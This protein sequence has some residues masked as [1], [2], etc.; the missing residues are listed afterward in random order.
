MNVKTDSWL[1]KTLNNANMANKQKRR[2]NSAVPH[3]SESSNSSVTENEQTIPVVSLVTNSTVTTVATTVKNL[4]QTI[5][6]RKS[7]ISLNND[8]TTSEETKRVIG[9]ATYSETVRRYTSLNTSLSE[10][11]EFCKK[12]K[13]NIANVSTICSTVIPIPGRKCQRKDFEKSYYLLHNRSCKCSR[14]RTTK[15]CDVNNSQM[16]ETSKSTVAIKHGKKKEN[17][18]CVEFLDGKFGGKVSDRGWSVWY[19]SKRKQSL[20]PLA[21]S[22]LEMIHQTVWQMEEAEIFKCPSSENNSGKQSSS[23]TVSFYINI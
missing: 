17:A 9:K 19:S 14:K 3:S 16:E 15:N 5:N 22:K 18:G 21:L 1:I 13:L 8:Q 23:Y 20:S 12:S 2:K 6:S 10:K 4:Q 11:K 7:C